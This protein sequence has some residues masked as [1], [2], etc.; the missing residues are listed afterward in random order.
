[1]SED[2]MEEWKKKC[3]I[4]ILNYNSAELTIS[5]TKKLRS[6]GDD[7]T[8]VIVDNCSTDESYK[9]ISA[10]Y[11]NDEYVHII[12][13]HVNGGYAVGNNVGLKY[14]AH[15]CR[16]IDTVCIMN[17]DIVVYN[18]EIFDRLYQ[19][20]WTRNRLFAITA[21]TI[22]NGKVRY[23]ND[24]GWQHLT[25]Q[26]MMLGGTLLGKLVKPVIR[27][28]SVQV[29]QENV[30]Y[31]D[32]IQGC[33]FMAKMDIFLQVNFFDEGTFLYEEEAILA[34]KIQR[35]GFQEAVLVDAFVCHN[36]HEK[37]KRLISKKSKIFDMKC[38]YQSR[39]YYVCRYSD[40][41][42]IQK[43]IIC[44]FLD[45]DYGIKK[46]FILLSGKKS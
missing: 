39:K 25:T 34:K 4:L 40:L 42:T 45:L 33:F 41:S 16:Q 46:I 43:K 6:F 21:Q 30:A 19:V 38:F 7:L 37:N 27:Y 36:H 10:K 9:K 11:K 31:V 14:I 20:L 17:P 44:C 23:P 13:N 24:F 29:D 1:M 22:Y 2:A 18:K 3:A 32:I 5:T 15:H 8:I 26:Y 35:A 28:K 12:E